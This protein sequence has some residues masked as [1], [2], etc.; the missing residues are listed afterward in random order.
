MTDKSF[1]L[2]G[3]EGEDDSY[4]CDTCGERFRVWDMGYIGPKERDNTACNPFMEFS[5]ICL[6]CEGVT[7]AN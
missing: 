4:K 6:T 3:Q 1:R 7:S 5:Q 2:I